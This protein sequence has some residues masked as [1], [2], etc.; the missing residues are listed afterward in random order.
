M[1]R[2]LREWKVFLKFVPMSYESNPLNLFPTSFIIKKNVTISFLLL[3]RLECLIVNIDIKVP[4]EIIS[5]T[6]VP[7]IY[8]FFLLNR[9]LRICYR[10]LCN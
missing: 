3:S 4:K 7:F 6:S 10:I 8:L 5:L 1:E 9:Q 2:H